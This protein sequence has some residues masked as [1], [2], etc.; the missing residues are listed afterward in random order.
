MT[1]ARG[2]EDHNFIN[3]HRLPPLATII[4]VLYTDNPIHRVLHCKSATMKII[5]TP[6]RRRR[7]RRLQNHPPS[8]I[9]TI[10]S[11]LVGVIT[12][13]LSL[14]LTGVHS[15]EAPPPIG[16]CCVSAFTTLPS[17][18]R[19]R[20]TPTFDTVPKSSSSSSTTT[21]AASTIEDTTKPPKSTTNDQELDDTPK[22]KFFSLHRQYNH[23]HRH[24]HRQHQQQQRQEED[25]DEDTLSPNEFIITYLE[26]NGYLLTTSDGI[27]VLIDPILDGDLDFG[28]PDLYKASK[29]TL[30]SNGLIDELPPTIDCLLLTQGLDD[31]AHVR[32]LTLLAR[33]GRLVDTTILAPPSARRALQQSGLLTP[34][35]KLN[36]GF[37]NHGDKWT[38]KPSHN[39]S[40]GSLKVQATKGALVGPPW[41]T[42]ENGYI[43]RP[44]RPSQSMTTSSST[45]TTTTEGDREGSDRPPSIYIEPHVEFD[46]N[47][48][49]RVGPVDVVISPIEGQQIASMLDLVF[50]PSK[51][52]QLVELLR[53]KV[54]I[55]MFNGNVDAS[56]PV[57][58][59]VSTNGSEQEFRQRLDEMSS[60]SS[61]KNNVSPQQRKRNARIENLIPGQDRR[62]RL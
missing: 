36:V 48:L 57:S 26:I 56:G 45:T 34:T 58:N 32:T 40:G 12:I 17:A 60:S 62:I 8:I 46:P 47:E 43:L 20:L 22:T 25:E 61:N 5:T 10:Q 35:N 50:G 27:T 15:S 29:K 3:L 13:S 6:W 53:P 11:I 28:I 31:H 39:R 30:P 52:I 38:I 42:R 24:R 41:Q 16:C 7:R 14:A 59:I 2:Q 18:A 9:P 54:I 1:R 23:R 37:L 21:A 19:P 4:N 49:R 33:S 55:P 44:N 51:T